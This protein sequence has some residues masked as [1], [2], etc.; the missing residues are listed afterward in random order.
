MNRDFRVTFEG[1]EPI[2]IRSAEDL[3]MAVF[4]AEIAL[5]PGRALKTV[6]EF[7]K[8]TKRW[9]CTWKR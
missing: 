8:V 3:G 4:R 1:A 6:H 5:G 2:V 9:R 7:N